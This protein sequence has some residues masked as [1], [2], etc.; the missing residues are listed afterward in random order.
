MK[1]LYG[2]KYVFTFVDRQQNSHFFLC[3]GEHSVGSLAVPYPTLSR[4][5][6]AEKWRA[7]KP[8]LAWE[9]AGTWPLFSPAP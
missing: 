3:V 6:A 5:E 1:K 7:L 8:S 9:K 4:G 2:S